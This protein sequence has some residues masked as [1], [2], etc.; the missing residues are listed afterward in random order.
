MKNYLLG[1]LSGLA[2]ATLYAVAPDLSWYFW[3]LF[4]AS[5]GLIVL[6][7]DIYFGSRAENQVR[8]GWVGLAL[9]GGTGAVLQALVWSLV[10]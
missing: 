8:A 7:V 5:L 4:A 10:L 1:V 2:G 3:L 9:F 6:S